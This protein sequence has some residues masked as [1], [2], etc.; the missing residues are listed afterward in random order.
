VGVSRQTEFDERDAHPAPRRTRVF[1]SPTALKSPKSETS[2][3]GAP[4]F[5]FQGEIKKGDAHWSPLHARC[6]PLPFPKSG[7][8]DF[9]HSLERPKSGTSDFGWERAQVPSAELVTQ[10]C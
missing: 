6:R 2:D 4:T 10:Y 7:V 3:F 9:G 5:P 8:P 1:P